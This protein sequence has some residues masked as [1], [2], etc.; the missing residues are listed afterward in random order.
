MS[1]KWFFL[2]ITTITLFITFIFSLSEEASD[3]F[4]YH[5]SSFLIS[6]FGDITNNLKFSLFEITFISM[7]FIGLLFLINLIKGLIK[8]DK[9][10]TKKYIYNIYMMIAIILLS[11]NSLAGVAYHRSPI[12]LPFYEDKISDELLN[13]ALEYYLKDYNSLVNK[14]NR[15]ENNVSICPYNFNELADIMKKESE[16]LNEISSYYYDFSPRA[17][18]TSFSFLLSEFHITGVDFPFTMEANVNYLMPSIDLPFTMAH[19]IAHL[20]GVM[21][22]YDANTVALYICLNSKYDYVRYSGYFRGFYRLLEIKRYTN[23]NEYVN[24]FNQLDQKILIDNANYNRYFKEHNILEDVSNF[25]NN[26]YLK[27]NGQSNGTTSYEDISS[28]IPGG[29]DENGHEI[30]IYSKYSPYQKL[31]I[32]HYIKLSN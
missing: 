21:R 26:I 3:F 13:N 30:R 2:I 14:F 23:Y 20:K 1:K 32:Q 15:D 22:E 9:Y 17:K 10:K 19:E 12:D 28:T 29:Y 25:I 7:I 31:M 24:I 11:Y 5:F 18:A 8:K 27:L 16:K 6:F 4:C